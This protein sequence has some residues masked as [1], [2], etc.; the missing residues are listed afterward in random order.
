[1]IHILERN[2]WLV[3]NLYICSIW[4]QYAVWKLYLYKLLLRIFEPAELTLGALPQLSK[5][6][7]LLFGPVD[8]IPHFLFEVL[9]L[10]RHR[11]VLLLSFFQ[12]G[13]WEETDELRL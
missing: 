1:M 9:F 8:L 10:H 7:S 13:I 6:V 12:P 3:T 11:P 2:I 5:P 4:G